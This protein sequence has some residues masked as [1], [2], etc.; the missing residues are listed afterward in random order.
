LM[1]NLVEP[2]VY[3]TQEV[4]LTVIDIFDKYVTGGLTR[5]NV[6][7]TT[8][9]LER[10]TFSNISVYDALEQLAELSNFKFYVDDDN[11]LHFE[12]NETTSSGLTF[13]NTNTLNAKFKTSGNEIYNDVWV[14]GGSTLTAIREIFTSDGAGSEYTLKYSPY[15]TT[16][17]VAGSIFTGGVFEMVSVPGSTEQYLVSF[18]DKLIIFTSGTVA[19]DNMPP[20]GDTITMDYYRNS[21]IIKQGQDESSISQYGKR[22]KVIQDNN[23]EDPNTA[24]DIVQ[25]QLSLNKD[26]KKEG[27]LQLKGVSLLT[28]G[29]TAVVNLPYH[30][31]SNEVLTMTSV[32]YQFNSTTV[33]SE[34]V[35]KVT[36]SNTLKDVVDTLK[37]L[38]LDVKKLQ[39]ADV[40]SADVITRLKTGTGSFGFIVSSWTAQTW[41]IGSKFILAH[42]DNGRLGVVTGTQ[43]YLAGSFAKSYAFQVSGGET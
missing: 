21:P 12:E 28:P 22:S 11:D 40:N 10:I 24:I 43:P 7:T 23:I 30:N 29:E 19:S 9:T 3:N 8:T 31:V 39:A 5:V 20:S 15:N 27:T 26:P 34:S 4:S 2:E 18:N 35:I 17:D 41:D 6:N 42:P 13:N 16:I 1:D 37:Q 25:S 38:I 14:F 32:K 36:V 33:F